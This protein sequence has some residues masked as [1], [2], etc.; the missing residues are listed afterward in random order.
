[1]KCVITGHHR[2]LTYWTE[3][4]SRTRTAASQ[5]NPRQLLS[6]RSRF[7]HRTE[8]RGS[9]EQSCPVSRASILLRS[10][11]SRSLRV[12]DLQTPPPA[13]TA[14]L[15]LLG[16]GLLRHVLRRQSFR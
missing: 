5:R 16:C 7:V 10:A 15:P 9:G 1:L 2:A 3:A 13:T 12:A 11:L 6:G 4:I 8:S 14:P